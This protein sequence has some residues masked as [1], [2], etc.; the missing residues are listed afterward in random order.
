MT[1]PR[2][3]AAALARR[4]RVVVASRRTPP[5]LDDDGRARVLVT[6]AAGLIGG[7]VRPALS[8]EFQVRGLDLR[9]G[10]GVDWVR[11]MRRLESIAP[12]FSG[13][14]VVLDLA[15]VSSLSA[16][17]HE[18]RRNNVPATIN[19]FEAARQAGVRRVVFASS[20]HA[21]GMYEREEPWASVVGGVYEGLDPAT[22]P[23]LGVDVPV[24]PDGPYGVG[25]VLGEAVGRYYAD[26][27][28]LSVICLRIGTVN[29]ADRPT[30]IRHFATL[31]THRDLVSL[32]RCCVV[33]PDDVR[34]GIVY[35][36]SRNMWRL[37]DVDA[38]RELV[39]FEPVDDAE[40]YRE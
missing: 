21:V 40:A 30:T 17:W 28:G 36:V 23:R 25:K 14:D 8:G 7:I 9:A 5:P 31:L 34:F 27:C 15:A 6:G 37:W 33:A 16:S 35:G 18:V 13:I 26:A 19:A 2:S 20:N 3:V 38:A 1:S 29:R 22:F 32:L 4:G 11:D 39:G 10:P 12:A 24:R